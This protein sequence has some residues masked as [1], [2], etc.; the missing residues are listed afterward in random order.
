VDIRTASPRS[1]DAGRLLD[2]YL[3]GLEQRVAG[4]TRAGYV[5]AAADGLV[6]PAGVLLIGYEQGEAVACGGVQVIAPGVAELKR[7]FVAPAVRGL[8]LGRELL[9]AL[10]RAAVDLGCELAR[11]DSTEALAEAVALYRSAGYSEIGDYN[12]NPNATL[13]MERRLRETPG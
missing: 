9:H 2:A 6:P 7:M 1:P 5:D 8:G 13:W 4:W 3:G 11:L 10:E 12:R